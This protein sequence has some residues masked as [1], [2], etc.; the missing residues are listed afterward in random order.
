MNSSN[1]MRNYSTMRPINVIL[2]L[3]LMCGFGAL[4][5][6]Y[7]GLVT[8]FLWTGKGAVVSLPETSY[9]LNLMLGAIGFGGFIVS[10]YG[11][12]TSIISVVKRNDDYTI[13][14]FAS[15]IALGYVACVALLLNAAWVYRL[16]TTN[17][18]YS[19]FGYVITLYVAALI[20]ILIAT[21]VPLVKL[22][23]EEKTSNKTMKTI[24][25]AAFAI[26]FGLCLPNFLSYIFS[27]NETFSQ[28]AVITMKFGV[29][30]LITLSAA[31]VSLIAFMLF[32][33]ADKANKECKAGF[34]LF[35]ATTL[36]DAG[37]LI[38]CG[39]FTNI[40]T[41]IKVS[42]MAKTCGAEFAYGT[43]FAVMSYILGS[44]LV[45]A[46]AIVLVYSFVPHKK[47]EADIK[48]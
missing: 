47:K 46:F 26:N 23:G 20:I 11:F 7:G 8:P 42:F 18:G 3:I 31:I 38:A 14:A 25:G 22:F 33:K 15:Y 21:N 6:Y 35:G 27:I 12:V 32:N 17:N 37:G 19:E 44:L 1:S 28:S 36:V 40:Y 30:A 10:T 48:F 29:Y 43:E 13:K 16:T 4:G 9:A 45:L 41:K 24:V 5:I 2:F 39:V 34:Y